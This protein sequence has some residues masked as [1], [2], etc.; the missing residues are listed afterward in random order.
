[1]LVVLSTKRLEE[2]ERLVREMMSVGQRFRTCE[3]SFIGCRRTCPFRIATA[4]HEISLMSKK[5]MHAQV[6]AN[7]FWVA[8]IGLLAP[9]N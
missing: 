2:E 3:Y 6:H 7:N 5:N 8:E 4:F 1:M 9:Q